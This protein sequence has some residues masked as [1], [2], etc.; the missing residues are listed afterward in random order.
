MPSTFTNLH[1]HIVFCT[2]QRRNTIDPEW[3]ERLFEYMG[4]TIRGLGGVAEIV[5]GVADL[6]H[7]LI[8][9]KPTHTLADV[10]R[11]L[12]K[13]ATVWV[14]ERTGDL[15]FSWQ[16]GYA[17]FTVSATARDG[18]RKYIANQDEHHRIRSFLEEW[19]MLLD[20][21]GVEYDPAYLE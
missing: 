7:L 6:V 1:F 12:K 20:K 3:R 5:G 18:V 8:G 10:L 13:A 2:K 9:L 16:E 11:E 4:G 14:H 17:A 21:A 15:S 19:T